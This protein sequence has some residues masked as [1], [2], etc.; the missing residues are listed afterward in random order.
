MD[1]ATKLRELI[2]R[3]K[4]PST[5]N[6]IK[7]DGKSKPSTRIICITSGKGGVGKT[8]FTANLAIALANLNKKVVVIDADLGLANVDV[9]LGVI[10]QHTLLDVVKFNKS[11]TDV[12]TTGPRGI[13]VISGGSGI[14]DLVDMSKESLEILIE[15][16]NE[17]NSHADILLIDTGAGLSKSVM[18]FVLAADEIIV[19]TTSEPTSITDAYAMIKTIGGYKESKK[20]KVIINRVENTNEGKATFEKLKNAAEKFLGIGIEKLGFIIDDY[21]VSRA[22]KIQNPFI[23]EYPNSSAAK[24][25]EMIALKLIDPLEGEKEFI[26]T[27]SFINKVISLFR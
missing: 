25:I 2:N 11:I 22:V 20:I 23:I 26:K 18:S 7:S 8:N 6:I 3:K 21:H 14:H 27:Q 13:K 5:S 24:S 4:L 10:P 9:I 19:V 15:Q 16:F 17:I 1:Q 12:M